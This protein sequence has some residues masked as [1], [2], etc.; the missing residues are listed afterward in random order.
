MAGKLNLGIAGLIGRFKPVHNGAAIMLQSVCENAEHVIIGIGSCNKY[1]A[2][3][4]FTAK[5]SEDMVGIVLEDYKNYEIVHVPDFAQIPEYAD[6]KKWRDYISD[7][8]GR[9]DYF[10]TANEFV[11]ELMKEKY[12]IINPSLII[13]KEKHV[14]VKYTAS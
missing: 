11:A 12:K 6:G 13:P 7:K 14:M 4:P 5:E 9:F 2:R 8:F 3:N 1:N 10:V